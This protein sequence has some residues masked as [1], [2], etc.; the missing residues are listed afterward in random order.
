MAALVAWF[1]LRGLELEALME[2][3]DTPISTRLC[4]AT[5]VSKLAALRQMGAMMVI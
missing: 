4:K 1:E 2:L 5:A 3:L